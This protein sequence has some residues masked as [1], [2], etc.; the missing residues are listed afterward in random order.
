[1][2]AIQRDNPD[3]IFCGIQR[4]AELARHFASADLFLFPSLSETFGN[5]TLEAMASG[6]PTVAFNYGAA[7]E[8]LANG[9][10]GACVDSD[11]GFIQAAVRIGCDDQLRQAMGEK[12]CAAV[13]AL[14]PDR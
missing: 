2:A 13:A 5:V 1:R 11:D 3:F 14:R 7:G 8:H 4:G 12:A 9:V 10:H 6:I